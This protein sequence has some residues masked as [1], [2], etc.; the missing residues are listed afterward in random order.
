MSTDQKNIAI[1]SVKILKG[2]GEK[3]Y[4]V[5]IG[6]TE[7]YPDNSKGEFPGVFDRTPH[8]NFVDKMKGLRVHLALLTDLISPKQVKDAD[9][10]EK[11]HVHGVSFTE[12][13]TEGFVLKGHRKS[14]LGN[15]GINTPFVHFEGK[16]MEEYSLNSDLDTLLFEIR[17]EAAD[18]IRGKHAPD[19]Q[20][21]LPFEAT[22]MQVEKP[23]V[24][25]EKET[26]VSHLYGITPEEVM[27][28]V[29][30]P[31]KGK[32]KVKQTADA[33]SGEIDA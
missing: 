21:E 13:K 30:E 31:K 26:D 20:G 17:Q 1:H 4:N 10:I 12:G 16:T 22:S 7:I 23:I 14:A 19:P 6:Y 28:E 29:S 11:F 9:L 32:K 25:P 15:V 5:L 33:R 27:A 8:A 24:F 2:K 18:Y 3:P